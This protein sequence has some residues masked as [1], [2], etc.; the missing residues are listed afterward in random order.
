MSEQSNSSSVA[1]SAKEDTHI[2]DLPIEQWITV[3]E[4]LL[5]MERTAEVEQA[6]SLLSNST[7]SE[8]KLKV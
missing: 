8:Y 7:D 1:S 2:L 4:Q 3:Q 6:V 5:E